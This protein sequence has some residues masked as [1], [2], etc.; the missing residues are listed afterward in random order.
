[1]SAESRLAIATEGL[2]SSES[3]ST[4]V[5]YT[6]QSSSIL[7]IPSESIM[8]GENLTS[9]TVSFDPEEAMV[10]RD[11]NDVIVLTSSDDSGE[12]SIG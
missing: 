7:A 10:A 6:G 8:V 3:S 2:R 1:M 9:N 5:V 11:N 12:V 4:T